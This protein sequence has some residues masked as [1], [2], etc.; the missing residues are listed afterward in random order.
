MTPHDHYHEGQPSRN[1]DEY[2]VKQ[3]AELLKAHRARLDAE[4]AKAAETQGN[5]CCPKC[6][7][8]LNEV[9]FHHVKID[10]CP[11]CEGIFLDKGELEMIEYVDRNNVS[12]FIGTMFGLKR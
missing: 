1:E 11:K 10:K 12:R 5:G 9:E 7:V 8:K 6:G 3:D 2:F 4:R